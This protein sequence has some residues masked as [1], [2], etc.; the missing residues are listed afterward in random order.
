MDIKSSEK[1]ILSGNNFHLMSPD[2]GVVI[3]DKKQFKEGSRE[4]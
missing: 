4:I 2:V 1:I 3:K